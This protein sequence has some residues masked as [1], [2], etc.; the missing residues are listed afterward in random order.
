MSYIAGAVHEGVLPMLSSW[1]AITPNCRRIC[2]TH[3]VLGLRNATRRV[4]LTSRDG[5]LQIGVNWLGLGLLKSSLRCF[6]MNKSMRGGRCP[7]LPSD[8]GVNNNAIPA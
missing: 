8:F 5:S 6:P 4:E 2:E 1:V 7:L 3:V